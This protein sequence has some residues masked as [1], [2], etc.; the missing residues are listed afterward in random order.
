MSVLHIDEVYPKKSVYPLLVHFQNGYTTDDFN[1]KNCGLFEDT[2]TGEKSLATEICNLVYAGKE[3]KD[4]LDKTLILARN[5]ITGKVRLIEVGNIEL[6]PVL[7]NNLDASTTLDTSNLELSRKFG[8]KKQKQIMEQREKLKVNTE[9]VTNQ[10]HNVTVNITEDQL[11]I[12]TY[13]KADSDDFYIPPI[14]RAASK[15][16][17]IYDK[18]Q[19]LTSEQY[20]KIIS[21]IEDKDYTSEMLPWIKD[22]AVIKQA[23]KNEYTVLAL[24]AS[25]LLKLYFTIM[26]EITK[27]NYTVCE[28]SGTLN[29]IILSNF[30]TFSN[31][32]RS[33]SVQ[34]KD[35]SLCHAIVFILLVNNYKY[36]AEEFSIKLKMSVRTLTNKIKVTGASM[37]TSGN[38]KVV[39]LKLPLSTPGF[40]R[41]KSAKF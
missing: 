34:L 15:V 6:K 1:S 39:Q 28:S 3:Q 41:R 31:N 11:D 29:D 13:L 26:R 17:E 30:T 27:K 14:N 33:R 18:H 32:K 36:D 16:E 40:N 24:Y 38:K 9:T 25:C 7:K 2:D 12:S 37:V 23:N 8:S 19:I 5:K 22:F 4:D 20:E 35:K 21:E 10:M